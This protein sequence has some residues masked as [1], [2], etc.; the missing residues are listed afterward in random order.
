M[1]RRISTEHCSILLSSTVSPMILA[2]LRKLLHNSSRR[3]MVR[4]MMPSCRSAL[5]N[6]SLRAHRSC[7]VVTSSKMTHSR[8]CRVSERLYNMK[9][10][11][12]ANMMRQ[13]AS[14]ATSL[15]MS[16]VMRPS[17]GIEYCGAEHHDVN[18]I[19]RE[20]RVHE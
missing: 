1:S 14:S 17:S 20:R 19:G 8:S 11:I 2:A 9:R 10:N 4:T 15:Y 5:S 16:P 7:S 3:C 6:K 18:V 13:D 12:L